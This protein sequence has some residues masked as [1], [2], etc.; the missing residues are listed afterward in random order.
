MIRANSDGTFTVVAETTG[1]EFGTYPSRAEAEDRLRQIE[2]FKKSAR[3]SFVEAALDCVAT[4]LETGNAAEL[5]ARLT[6]LADDY[7][8]PE[9][10]LKVDD[11]QRMV[12]GWA[13]IS[14]ERGAVS[15]DHQDDHVPI[16]ELQKAV[17]DKFIRERVGKTMH[18]GRKTHEVVDSIVFT[19]ELQ[20]ALGIDLPYEGWFVGV[21]VHDNN[22]WNLVKSGKYRAFSIGGSGER[23]PM[24]KLAAVVEGEQD[25]EPSP[26]QSSPFRKH[27]AKY[28][29]HQDNSGN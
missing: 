2:H 23:H 8:Q 1:R 22:T 18:K 21:K 10:V 26:S 16:H 7:T 27:L 25:G 28:N 19:Q 3:H 4:A 13:S 15:I 9:L 17:H 12:W 11:E 29:P 20:K 14:K 5:E 6:K 24:K